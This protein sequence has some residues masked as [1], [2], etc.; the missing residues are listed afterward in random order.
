MTRWV[1]D[2]HFVSRCLYSCQFSSAMCVCSL[3][4][5]ELLV[6]KIRSKIGSPVCFTVYPCIMRVVAVG[7]CL[8]PA[9]EE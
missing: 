5:L 9:D 6:F 8:F 4:S 1:K 2:I 3:L 7:M